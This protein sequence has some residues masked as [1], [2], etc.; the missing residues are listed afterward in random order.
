MYG[1]PSPQRS[2]NGWKGWY[3][4]IFFRS[5]LELSFLVNYVYRF[6]MKME[7][8]EKA[9]Y[10]IQYRDYK[11]VD[12]TYFPDYII[13]GKYMVEVKPKKLIKTS[14]IKAKTKAA[15]EF[16]KEHNLKYKIFEPLKIDK[17]II[18]T[19]YNNKEVVFSKKYEER[20]INYLKI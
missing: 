12:R 3:N 17:Q 18:T 15:I 20:F 5:I 7:S 2:G 9:K 8:G 10:A 11:G 6:K 13:N 16:C 4:G 19:L 14:L 1:K